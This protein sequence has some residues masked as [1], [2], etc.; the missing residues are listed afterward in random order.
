MDGELTAAE[1]VQNFKR[2]ALIFGGVL[3]GIFGGLMAIIGFINRENMHNIYRGF[4]VVLPVT[5]MLFYLIFPLVVT[6]NIQTFMATS[7]FRGLRL[8]DGL[9]SMVFTGPIIALAY[10]VPSYILFPASI[11]KAFHLAK[12]ADYSTNGKFITSVKTVLG[13][14]VGH[15]VYWVSFIVIFKLMSMMD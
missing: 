11:A 5:A 9:L 8:L 1:Q 2:S 13:F 10:V 6:A 7:A 3:L 4:T 12:H 15:I 14:L